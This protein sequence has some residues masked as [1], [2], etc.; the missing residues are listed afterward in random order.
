[1]YMC[2]YVLY[3]LYVCIFTVHTICV[4]IYC[5][6]YMCAHLLY[7]LYVR[8]CAVHT[9]CVHIYC[10]YYMCVAGLHHTLAQVRL[11]WV[12]FT[13]LQLNASKSCYYQAE[14]FYCFED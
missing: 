5:T 14:H 1:M 3:I 4:H 11:P 13:F 10:V 9:I 7:I 12:L 6:Y 8:I 2:V